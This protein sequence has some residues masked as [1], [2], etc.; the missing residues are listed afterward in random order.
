ML[1]GP[2]QVILRAGCC[3]G[4]T[5][6]LI[7]CG[8][9]QPSRA[10]APGPLTLWYNQPAVEWVEALPVGNGRLGAMVFGGV[11]RE[12]LQLNEDTI[13]AGGPYDPANPKALET[14]KRARE[15]IFS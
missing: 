9:I 4:V 11:E 10:A 3:L 7:V 6:P 14:Y 15:L 13:W 5:I 12:R 8:D 2:I 1:R